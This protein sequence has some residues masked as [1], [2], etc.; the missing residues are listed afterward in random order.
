MG[1]TEYQHKRRF[2]RT[3]EP[4]GVKARKTG[5][6]YVVQKHAAS[7]LHYDFRLELDGV[8]KSWAVPKGP[9]LDPTVKRLAV[10]V[11]DHPVD[12]GSF[13]GTIP[14][15]QY[16]GGTVML[17]D[18][19][20]WEPVGDPRA[21]YRKGKLKFQ[22]HGQK[23][24]GGWTLVRSR[25]RPGAT[26]PQ[27][28]LIKERDD[29][30]RD[31]AEGDVLID[32]PLS[33]VTDRDLA[34]IASGKDAVWHSNRPDG[35]AKRSKPAKTP[36]KTRDRN[37]GASSHDKLP[38]TVELQLAT[39]TEE[40][41]SGDEW[42]HEVKFDGYRMLCRIDDGRV[43]FISRNQQDWTARL[44]PLVEAAAKLPVQQALLDGE[45]VALRPDGTSDFQALQNV[46]REGRV[47]ELHYFVFDL[48]HLDGEDLRSLPLEERKARLEPLMAK[49]GKKGFIHY[50]DHVVGHGPDFAK[51]A[52]R[53]HLE[54]IISKR[55]DRP[56]HSGRSYDWLKIKCVQ[57]EEFV[58][59]GYTDPAGA[60]Q[61]FGAL[62]LGYHDSQGRLKYAGKVGT[63]F[64]D[65]TLGSLLRRLKPLERKQPAFDD[66]AQL[67][68]VRRSHW[69]EPKLVAQIAF[70][71]RTRD[72]ILRHASFQGLREDKP[73][74]EVTLDKP[75][76]VKEAV[77]KSATA[78]RKRPAKASSGKQK[79]E[80]KA[81]QDAGHAL[82]DAEAETFA[83]VRL[84]SADKVLYPPMG[85]TKLDLAAY[86]RD[87]ADWI[88]P[89]LAHRPLVLVRCPE[90][91]GKECFYQKHPG[92]G[93]P[94]VLRRIPIKEKSRTEPYVLVD[95][96][97]GLISL[98]QIGA[99][100]IHA[101]G[102]RED[103][104][105]RPDRLIF[106]LDPDPLVP[107]TRVVDSARE[108][109]EFLQE[110]GL[111]SFVKT[112]GGKGLH[113]VL[114]I[115]RRHDWDEAKAFCKL[116][117]EAIVAAAPD[118]YTANMSKA[119]RGN[120]IFIDY[121]RNGRGAT[122]VVPYSSRSKP[123]AT[124]STPLTWRELSAKIGSDHFTVQTIRQRLA[125]LKRDPWEELAT[126]RQRLTEP[127][128]KLMKLIEAQG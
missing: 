23:L 28:L 128:K 59:G 36:R 16:G 97:E 27:W 48:M 100:E 22:L 43:A 32:E 12:Y 73:A 93:T 80:P 92:V 83:G 116:V 61:G 81:E 72:G 113:L 6:A 109:R 121:L 120:K 64:N 13:E 30:A 79:A 33:V 65:R 9:S 118:R 84:T 17:W 62:L 14:E 1:L 20:T 110:I 124:V 103:Q 75:V 111:E 107:W 7:H 87:I 117:A 49:A 86:Y 101:W 71:S 3:P 37:P 63:G 40:A 24:R 58:I 78:K 82:Y 74:E 11:E 38:K 41:P 91:Q 52:C 15:G 66:P 10:E 57:Q 98:T 127:K 8:L 125:S 77:A 123:N 55:R 46:F 67:S 47:K 106:D 99:L 115:E 25:P 114:P 44:G 95:N 18:N 2:D 54:G 94:D 26:K 105:E 112:T 104:L 42:L 126:L 4:R 85:I 68:A 45:V 56:Y 119:K 70:G 102:S 19:G 108:V 5:W 29:E 21:D 53:K 35:K 122:A 89:H 31:T 88:L 34:E 50:S 51:E 39:L 96:V 69:V 60:R 90:G 76:P